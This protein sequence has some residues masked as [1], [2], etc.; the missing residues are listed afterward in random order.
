MVNKLFGTI[1]FRIFLAVFLTTFIVSIGSSYYQIVRV[2]FAFDNFLEQQEIELANMGWMRNKMEADRLRRL[3]SLNEEFRNAII[4]NTLL[5]VAAGAIAALG[6]A[7]V[8]A[9]NIT[10]PLGKMEKSIGGLMDD[11]FK[12][13]LE[14][15]GPYEIQMLIQRFNRLLDELSRVD[16]L[17]A[18][19]V[20]DITHELRTPLTKIRGQLEGIV[21]GVYKPDTEL[22]ENLLANTNQ[23][24]A[25][26]DR[27]QEII[28]IRSGQ[29]KLKKVNI[30]LAGMVKSV[31]AGYQK[32]GVKV[33]VNIDKGSK[34]KADRVRFRELLDN[35]ISN[36]FKYTKQGQ[37][38]I[39]ANNEQLKVS[40]TG[41]GIPEA[42]LPNIFERFY[43]VD[44]S[45]NDQSG[46][47]GLG[48]AIA[49][50]IA[51]AHGFELAVESEFEKGSTFI[52]SFHS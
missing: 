3:E 20:S 28:E 42:E 5:S 10:G 44:K 41:M 9:K 38:S 16:K 33:V 24:E 37:I 1:T 26:I 47:L 35:L 34:V 39:E 22:V 31:L 45:R 32:D 40:D 50:E 48:L 30:D 43:R 27:L 13:R 46:G 4:Q 17:R 36:A 23:L 11:K 2:N 8:L 25:I 12:G 6:T 15:E 14:E 7:F 21:D 29:I 19:L 51:D 49:S 52:I 18:D